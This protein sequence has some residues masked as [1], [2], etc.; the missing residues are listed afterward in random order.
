MISIA[1]YLA[2]SPFFTKLVEL[3]DL[4]E[5]SSGFYIWLLSYGLPLGVCIINAGTQYTMMH[6]VVLSV[7][8]LCNLIGIYLISYFEAS[9]KGSS[10]SLSPRLER[11]DSD[12]ELIKSINQI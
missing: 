1:A 7:A 5:V 11:Y 10:G 8:M 2:A 6:Y 9:S 4:A 3:S 12:E